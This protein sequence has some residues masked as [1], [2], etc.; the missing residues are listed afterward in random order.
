MQLLNELTEEFT[1]DIKREAPVILPG[2]RGQ[3]ESFQDML[4]FN[5]KRQD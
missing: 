4:K 5:L 2:L 1:R 3:N